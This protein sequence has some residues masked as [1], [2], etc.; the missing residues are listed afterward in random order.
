MDL[1]PYLHSMPRPLRA[2]LAAACETTL[3][4]LT[5]VSYGKSCSPKLA[6]LLEVHTGG[7]VMRWDM[8]PDEWHVIWPELI[9][10]DGAPSIDGASAGAAGSVGAGEEL[11]ADHG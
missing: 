8:C 6:S 4:H 1:K 5:N 9:G 2:E 11:V 3:G 7:A 10:R